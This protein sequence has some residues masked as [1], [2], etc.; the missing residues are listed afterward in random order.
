MLLIRR[1]E[2]CIALGQE[3]RQAHFDHFAVPY[4]RFLG[5]GKHDSG[6]QVGIETACVSFDQFRNHIEA[7]P[8]CM[9]SRVETTKS[10]PTD[11]MAHRNAK[12]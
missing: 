5:V 8:G 2:H 10:G 7:Y 4:R 3:L 6:Q 9:P 11:W 12:R 1:G